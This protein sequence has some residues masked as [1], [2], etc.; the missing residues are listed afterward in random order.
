MTGTAPIKRRAEMGKPP[1]RMAGKSGSCTRSI[2]PSPRAPGRAGVG[3]VRAAECRSHGVGTPRGLSAIILVEVEPDL[4]AV[5]LEPGLEA[6]A[7]LG[8]EAVDQ[9]GPPL[10]EQGLGR[11]GA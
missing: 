2:G 4:A 3:G 10:S 8:P 5:E 6:V 1:R 11:A 9:G 7:G